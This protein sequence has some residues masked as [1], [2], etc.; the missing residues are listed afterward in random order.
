MGLISEEDKKVLGK[1][2]SSSLENDVKIVAYLED[3][4][5]ASSTAKS[6]LNEL[7]E[8]D[9]RI[10]VVFKDIEEY[11]GVLPDEETTGEPIIIFEDKPNLIYLGVPAGYEFSTF[12]EDI[13]FVSTNKF[14]V[15]V[16][17]AKKVAKSKLKE[18]IVFYTPM[19][20][21]C[22]KMSSTVRKVSYIRNDV[23]TFLVNALDFPRL[24]EKYKVSAV[25]KT[26]LVFDGE[27]KEIEGAIPLESLADY[28]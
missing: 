14:E 17:F 7:S 27:S 22:P 13:I 4:R 26:V 1:L 8:L 5:D 2:L 9:D 24:A 16:S 19:C 11:V 3:G 20:P 23:N 21:F 18:A 15:P 28:L 6:L 10:K 25:P 12:L